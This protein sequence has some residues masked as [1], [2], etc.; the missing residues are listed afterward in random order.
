VTAAVFGYFSI[1]LLKF[2]ADKGKF[3]AFAYYCWAV[4]AITLIASLA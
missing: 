3:G 1:R 2:V 4:G